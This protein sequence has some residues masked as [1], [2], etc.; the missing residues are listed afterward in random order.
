MKG[1]KFKTQADVDR[2]VAEGHGSGE[3]EAYKPWLRVQD[4]PSRGRSRKVAGIKVDRTYHVISDIEYRYLNILEFSE[5]VVDIREQFPL[6]PNESARAIAE[7]LGIAYPRFVG[8]TVPFV[9]TTDFVLTVRDTGGSTRLAART[10]K[11]DLESI[12]PKS[13]KRMLEKLELERAIWASQGVVDWA[14]VTPE[15]MGTILP[16]NLEFIRGGADRFLHLDTQQRE[17]F[18]LHLEYFWSL[19]RTLSSVIRSAA[20]AMSLPYPEAISLFKNLAW[21]KL[22]TFDIRCTELK[23]TASCPRAQFYLKST[24]VKAA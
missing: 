10:V 6:L 7:G 12:D 24:P 9:M 2:C 8:T 3:R 23:L 5:E 4:V 14:L 11:P 17:D 21:N 19:E 20:R 22:I 18:A 13:I 1:R 15:P 16:K